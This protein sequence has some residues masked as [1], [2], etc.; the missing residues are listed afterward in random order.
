MLFFTV[1]L[2]P[3]FTISRTAWTAVLFSQPFTTNS[4]GSWKATL[5]LLLPAALCVSA[6]SRQRQLHLWF[7]STHLPP[8]SKPRWMQDPGPISWSWT[9][10]RPIF[11]RRRMVRSGTRYNVWTAAVSRG[12]SWRSDTLLC[13]YLVWEH[14][15]C[16]H[17]HFY[18][19][20]KSANSQ[21][22]PLTNGN[23]K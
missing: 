12:N 19:F 7:P 14:P 9:A 4:C 23:Q 5:S 3:L 15:L 17:A 1:P 16:Q 6:F 20:N 10:G 22:W 2:I 21:T 11:T 8:P 18:C 13:Y